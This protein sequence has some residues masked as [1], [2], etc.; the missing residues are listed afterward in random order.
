MSKGPRSD[1]ALEA[2]L[3]VASKRG[4]VMILEKHPGS[5][6]D[7]LVS[8][9]PG[10]SAVQVIRVPHIHGTL[11]GIAAEHTARIARICAAPLTFGIT[12]EL[13][14][15]SPWGTMRF[16]RI[17]GLP[18]TEL[19]LLGNVRDTL[20]KGSGSG[21][22]RSRW[23]KSR[24]RSARHSASHIPQPAPDT[25]EEAQSSGPTEPGPAGV[26]EPAPARF[27]RRKAR[28]MA[29]AGNNSGSPGD[30]PAGNNS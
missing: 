12:R 19:D 6:F 7:F 26:R 24:K 20:V 29:A 5:C 30:S 14:F 9:P 8:G 23:R 17:A 10:T 4:E 22:L 18:L 15:W 11:A 2:A 3:P 25:G 16:F 28:E 13:W 27:L 21:S 1:R